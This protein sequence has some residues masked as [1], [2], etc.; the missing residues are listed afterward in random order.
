MVIQ[1]QSTTGVYF[2][3]SPYQ[4]QPQGSQ[5][6]NIANSYSFRPHRVS[7]STNH[8]R[9]EAGETAVLPLPASRKIHAQELSH[10]GVCYLNPKL[11]CQAPH[12]SPVDVS[13][14]DGRF[15]RRTL[16]VPPR[17]KMPV[18]IRPSAIHLIFSFFFAFLCFPPVFFFFFGN[19][20]LHKHYAGHAAVSAPPISDKPSDLFSSSTTKNE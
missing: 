8:L 7:V 19:M 4:T 16:P 11:K 12:S 14:S 6:F 9:L 3:R 1:Q 2:R 17:P 10:H 18:R 15:N 13:H 20:S 5:I